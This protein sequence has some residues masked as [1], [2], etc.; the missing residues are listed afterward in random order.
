MPS[1]VVKWWD[2]GRGFGFLTRDDGGEDVACSY[3]AIKADGCYRTLGE[4]QKVEYGVFDAPEG[5]VAFDVRR[6][7]DAAGTLVTVMCGDAVRVRV[8]SWGKPNLHRF[9]ERLRAHGDVK[10]S[11]LLVRVRAAP[12]ELTVFDDGLA[13]V[14]GTDDEQV[15]R[16]IVTR[17]LGVTLPE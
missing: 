15:A 6:V 8:T 17:W 3:S 11:P 16:G 14:K 12:I 1:G 10:E 9:A 4:G 7:F 2:D 13:V 5:P